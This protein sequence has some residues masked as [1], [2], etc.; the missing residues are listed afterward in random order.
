MWEDCH[1]ATSS[2]ISAAEET[3]AKLELF[4]A[5]LSSLKDSLRR[6]A[7][8]RRGYRREG[9]SDSGIRDE[10]LY[11]LNKVIKF[12]KINISFKGAVININ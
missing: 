1:Y 4:A 9:S 10:H 6:D 12:F 5:E 3:Q 8:R 7:Q 2:A 11:I